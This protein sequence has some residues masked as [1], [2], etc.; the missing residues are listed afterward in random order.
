MVKLSLLAQKLLV[1]L[2]KG[3]KNKSITNLL[4]RSVASTKHYITERTL[5]AGLI[6]NQT[7]GMMPF[8]IIVSPSDGADALVLVL[9]NAVLVGETDGSPTFWPIQ[10]MKLVTIKTHPLLRDVFVLAF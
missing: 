2:L 8:V 6:K 1:S 9:V 3:K 7:V 4:L 5:Q 10:H